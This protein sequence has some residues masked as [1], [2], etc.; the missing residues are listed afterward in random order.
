M[1]LSGL[2]STARAADDARPSAVGAPGDFVQVEKL[3]LLINALPPDADATQS[4]IDTEAFVGSGR[5]SGS[6]RARGD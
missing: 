6:G 5:R 1:H 3:V 4:A 2:Q